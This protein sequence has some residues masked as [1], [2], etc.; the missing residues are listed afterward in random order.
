MTGQG[1]RCR[2]LGFRGKGL[3]GEGE[4]PLLGEE[5]GPGLRSVGQ[6]DRESESLPT[7]KSQGLEPKRFM[8]AR[9]EDRFS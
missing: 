5:G 7:C 6:R 9:M 1:D 2:T 4:S 3:G 8:V